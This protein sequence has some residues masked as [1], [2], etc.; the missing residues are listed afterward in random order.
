MVHKKFCLIGGKK[1]EEGRR[2]AIVYYCGKRS[3]AHKILTNDTRNN[4]NCVL[5][6]V[7]LEKVV[8]K[9]EEKERFFCGSRE[10]VSTTDPLAKTYH[11]NYKDGKRLKPR[12]FSL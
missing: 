5:C 12:S 8:E 4:K 10:S 3:T 1:K 11:N 6:I 7:R 9:E 2:R